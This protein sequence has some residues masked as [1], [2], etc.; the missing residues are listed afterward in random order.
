MTYNISKIYQRFIFIICTI[1]L[2]A[3]SASDVYALSPDFWASSSRLAS[4]K[5]KRISVSETGMHIITNAELRSWG[6]DPEKV[7]VYGYGGREI[8]GEFTNDTYDDLPLLPCVRTSGGIVFYAVDNVK[9]EYQDASQLLYTHSIN[10]YS[11]NSYYFISDIDTDNPDMA[12]AN[13]LSLPVAN[14]DTVISSFRSRLLHEREMATLSNT[15]AI[16]LGEDFRTTNSQNFSFQ[17][18]DMADSDVYMSQQ[19]G[20]NISSGTGSLKFFANGTQLPSV[21]DDNISPIKLSDQFIRLNANERKISN[22]KDKLDLKIQFASTG[23]LR[24]ARLDYIE[25]TYNRNIKLNN[26]Q[27]LFHDNYNSWKTKDPNKVYAST[28]IIV[29][30][31]DAST[32]IWDITDPARPKNVV[33]SLNGSK[34]SFTITEKGYREFIAFNSDKITLRT[35]SPT[36]IP[37][38]NIHGMEQPDMVIITAPEFIDA[39]NRVADLHRNNDD[40][41]V[42]VLTPDV[43]YNE[44]SS[45]VEDVGAW[46]KALK[47]WHDRSVN[48]DNVFKYC[49]IIGKP[50]ADLK[51]INPSKTPRLPIWQSVTGV[52][53]NTSYSTD[54]YIGMVDDNTNF[55]ISNAKIRIAVGR[56]PV[57]TA[58]EAS[59]M[60]DKL[61]NYVNNPEF[62][63]WR[64]NILCI[65]DDQDN[66]VHLSQIETM[67]EELNKSKVGKNFFYDKLY[68]DSY[69]LSYSGT[70]AGYPE[71]R[72][73]FFNKIDEGVLL[74]NYVGHANPKSWTHEGFLNWTDMNSFSNK[75]LP[76][77][78]A[79]TCEFLRWDDDDDIS[80][81]QIMWLNPKGGVIGM[82]CPS[83]SVYISQNGTLTAQYGKSFF[84][85]GSDGKQKTLGEIFIEGKNKYPS[86]DDNKLKYCLLADPAMRLPMPSYNVTVTKIGDTET[87]SDNM[88]EIS[89]RSK[90][91]ISGTITDNAG[92]ILED[93]NGTISLSLYDAE[94]SITTYGNGKDGKVM[95]YNDWNSRLFN[96]SAKVVDG[97][98]EMIVMTPLEIDNIYNN[99]LMSLYASSED[100]REAHA[101]F[102]DFYVYGFNAELEDDEDGPEIEEFRLNSKTFANGDWVN[103][104]PVMFATVSDI[105]GINI[106]DS[107]IGHK[108]TLTLDGNIHFDDINSFFKTEE[109]DPTRGSIVY[110]L[111]NLGTG[112]HTLELTVWDY[113]NNSS[114]ASINFNV[115]VGKE[116]QILNL[117]SDASPAKVSTVFSV[118]TDR[119]L[120][121]MACLFEVFDLSGRRV[122][123]YETNEST[124]INS[125]LSVSWNLCDSGGVRVP[126]GIY[127][128]KATVTTPEGVRSSKTKKMAVAEP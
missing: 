122:W 71:A 70:G 103:T 113:A 75:R 21:G 14:P 101:S 65:A 55:N 76:F 57:Q 19:F 124:D 11:N 66:G 121:D 36:D 87:T 86:T 96:G 40:M 63:A 128:Y 74:V 22:I 34:A 39:A 102:S 82:I 8:P 89:A 2:T 109:G 61:C 28:T 67:W 46:R 99:A 31:C 12:S 10:R 94:K 73:K 15:G 45:G 32:R 62:G 116:P 91:A 38:Q 78:Y 64:N 79:A 29:D 13:H 33:F 18:P 25:L 111:Q 58:T 85:P 53:Q 110:P 114:R 104:N 6:F 44:F 98:W 100:G 37:N 93:F 81:A 9:W 3:L 59:Q 51:M 17:L 47:M 27:I 20:S 115:G 49:M 118:E 112:K 48:S 107:G 126:R 95:H 35:S 7:N 42:H 108:I 69:P 119:P 41:T 1:L 90:T 80:G 16:I 92:N 127:M 72:S 77:L 52:S 84:S 97:K 26:G 24:T 117:S 54:D 4:G 105:S 120:S 60:A 56:W 43:I 123:K 106:S 125:T 23:A 88:A 68:L 30:G 83:R 5:W 50:T